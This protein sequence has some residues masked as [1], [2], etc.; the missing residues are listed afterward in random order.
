MRSRT[1]NSTSERDKYSAPVGTIE[2]F[3]TSVFVFGFECEFYLKIVPSSFFRLITL[4]T[5]LDSLQIASKLMNFEKSV[6]H[7]A[8]VRPP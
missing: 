7:L 3:V 6:S 8:G 1:R 2:C 5:G 4:Y